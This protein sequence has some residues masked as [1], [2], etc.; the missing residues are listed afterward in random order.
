[1]AKTGKVAALSALLAMAGQSAVWAE[2][3]RRGGTLHEAVLA[4][5][6]S[7]DCHASTTV[8]NLGSLSPHY[9]TLVRYDP[10][11]YPN[12]IGDLAESWTISE[13]GRTLVFKIRQNVKFHDGSA[14]TAKDVA[15]SLE[16]IRK[17]PQGIVSARAPFFSRVTSI[18]ATDPQTVVVRLSEREVAI[19]DILAN[20]FNCI[21]SAAKL[22][23]DPR[24]PEKEVMGTGP[25]KFVS[26]VPG[27]TWE[28]TRFDGYFMKGQPYLDGFRIHYMTG[29][30][31]LNALQSGQIH[32]E[33]RSMTPQQRD[34]LVQA[35]GKDVVV[36]TSPM[37]TMIKVTF[38]S[39]RA[40]FND[41]RVRRALNLALDRWAGSG[42][43]GKVTF[44]GP[45]GALLRPGYE[46]A[47][48]EAELE[49]LPGWGK[50]IEARRAEA[51][52]LL[53]EAGVPNLK[54][55][56]SNRGVGEP[57]VT[58]GTW[59][60]D[61]WRRIGVQVEQKMLQNPAWV[62]E[63]ANG[64]FDVLMDAIAE[65]SDDPTI[66]LSKYQSKDKT[67]FNTA[68]YIDRELDE[69]FDKQR[70]EADPAARR[71]L[72]RQIEK[73]VM[74]QAYYAPLF[75]AERI[76]VTDAKLKGWK[77]TPIQALNLDL[78]TVWLAE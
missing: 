37:V 71:A 46:L 78:S 12:I 42:P 51:K 53:A 8:Y 28:G 55:T 19:L 24:Y 68:R 70:S 7:T 1:M 14:L 34:R 69:L 9:S 73:R 64:T 22:E 56:M 47:P 60:I 21:Y 23:A 49:A 30:A 5:P 35:R 57:Y 63:R 10:Q 13:D 15:A 17:P 54:F 36:Q 67:P 59:V 62:A 32:A 25:F 33:F 48:S 27:A 26:R 31:I 2:T 41:P 61:Q 45:V 72:L 43:I 38:N 4:E 65:M 77:V 20:P 50:D 3:P 6:A 75:W 40:P 66:V 44:M 58:I 16:R 74:E 52:R 18:E 39:E 29:T 76:V 11:S